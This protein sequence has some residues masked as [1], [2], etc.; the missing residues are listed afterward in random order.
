[1]SIFG[2]ILKL[3]IMRKLFITMI[4]CAM[5]HCTFAQKNEVVLLWP[6]GAPGALGDKDEDKPSLT[7]YPAPKDKAN[8]AAVVICPGGGYVVHAWEKEGTKFAEWFNSIGVSAYVL[9]YRLGSWDH[10]RYQHPTMW[11]DGTR[12][13]RY[14]RS[15]A[16]EWGLNPEH[17]GIMGFS[18][19]GHLASTVGTH[20]DAGN[21]DSSDPI[22]KVSSRPSFLILAYPVISFT[23]P[24][25]HRFTRGVLIGDNPDPA[26]ANYLSSELQ[27]TTFTPP[28]FLVHADDDNGVPPENSILFY[29][30]LKKANVPAEMH[31]FNKGGHGFGIAADKPELAIWTDNLKNWLKSEGFLYNGK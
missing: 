24:Y 15:R 31:I 8:G 11:Q 6:N 13:M 2:C 17:I 7:F 10:K 1:L 23:T 22:E 5:F 12:A 21:P 19:G 16:K 29:L 3:K 26:L 4:A 9:K 25:T 30:A 28:T 27:V 20:F 14:V 18:A